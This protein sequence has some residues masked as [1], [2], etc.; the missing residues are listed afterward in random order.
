M[1]E[2]K[3]TTREFLSSVGEGAVKTA[4]TGNPSHVKAPFVDMARRVRAEVAP[5]DEDA[6]A[7]EAEGVETHAVH[8]STDPAPGPERTER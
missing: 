7:I 6:P 5:E 8:E 1:A 2:R 3:L 4:L